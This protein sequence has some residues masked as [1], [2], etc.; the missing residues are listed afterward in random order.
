M[1]DPY[2]GAAWR[3][4][5]MRFAFLIMLSLPAQSDLQLPERSPPGWSSGAVARQRDQALK[6]IT[7]QLVKSHVQFLSHDL[8]E[9]RDTGERG[10]EIA[11]EYVASQFTRMGARP[12]S[13]G[14]YLQSFE[15][16][17]G[18]EDRGSRLTVDGIT[19]DTSD[20]AFM[21][22]WTAREPIIRGEGVYVGQ[23]LRAD[24]RDDYDGVDVSG[25]I[26]FMIPG[27][28]ADWEEDMR[29]GL[30]ARTKIQVALDR[31]AR[32]VVMLKP[33][34][35]DAPGRPRPMAL[36]DG[37]TPSPRAAVTLGGEA[38]ATLLRAW[39]I[40]PDLVE[41]Q[42]Q[43][44]APALRI[45]AVQLSRARNVSRLQSW[46]VVAIVPGTD[47]QLRNEAIVFSAHL[48]HVGTGE[49]DEKGDAIYNGTHDN[50]LGIGKLLASAEAMV[51][52]PA[53]RTTVFVA[54]GAEE[55]GL[56]GSWH[57]VRQ[58][59]IPIERTVAALNHDGG[60][61]GLATDDFFAF[62]VEFTTLDHALEAAAAETGMVLNRDYRPPFAASQALL[63]RSD[64]YAFLAAG[65]PAVYLMD[66]FSIAGDPERGR[67]QWE[68]YLANV[69]HRQRDNFDPTWSLEAPAQ[70][71][72]LSVR[73]AWQLG[74]SERV[75]SLTPNALF[76]SRRGVPEIAGSQ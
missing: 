37:S 39:Q 71:A 16:L 1:Y 66:G 45:G 10:Y 24:G 18:G 54:A 8:L 25:R 65:V 69:N 50:A 20:A 28:P 42:A 40:D 76:P 15:V 68:H 9:G 55:R 60:L 57:Y 41:Q 63:F 6:V 11:R 30:L 70:M 31:G 62:G 4:P 7:P 19:I 35:T 22:D 38:S 34:S 26:V 17:V 2:P 33:G 14:S 47:P 64:Q 23:G 12:L 43:R 46:N 61:D 74:D 3:Y 72:R 59:A 36:A 44:G 67:Q 13:D 75:P 48:D 27:V 49:P 56:L 21:P 53:R 51:R 5:L 58:P 52:A 29:L 32:A 73:A